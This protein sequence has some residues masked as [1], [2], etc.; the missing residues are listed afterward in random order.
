M[1]CMLSSRKSGI[2]GGGLDIVSANRLAVPSSLGDG[3]AE[4]VDHQHKPHE[5][6]THFYRRFYQKSKPY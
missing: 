4:D 2:V 3:F 6:I 1:S 5:C